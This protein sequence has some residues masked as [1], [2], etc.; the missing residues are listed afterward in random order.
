MKKYVILALSILLFTACTAESTDD[1]IEPENRDGATLTQEEAYEIAI[2]SPCLEEGN[3]L[4]E[5]YYNDFTKTWWFETDIDKPG[6]N[7][8]CM[9]SEETKT[10]EINWMCTGLI[11]EE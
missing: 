10:A 7:P 3:V 1:P 4:N 2:A 11:V 9:V 8:E 6:C 5:A